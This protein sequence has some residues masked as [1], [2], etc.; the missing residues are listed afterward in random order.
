MVRRFGTA[1]LI[2]AALHGVAAAAAGLLSSAAVPPQAR[3]RAIKVFAVPPPE[4]PSF[5]GLNQIDATRDDPLDPTT[6]SS[7]PLEFESF[8]V[9]VEKIA[10]RAGV[11]FPF[12]TPGLALEQ[13]VPA[14]QDESR[15]SLENPLEA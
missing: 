9:D 5:P 6:L 13:L 8:R 4:D 3:P 1:I 15:S 7:S 10:Q 12:I 11:L 14:A 2:S